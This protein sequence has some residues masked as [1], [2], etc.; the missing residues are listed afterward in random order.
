MTKLENG[1]IRSRSRIDDLFDQLQGAS[2]FSKV[3]MRSSYQQLKAR[4]LR[5]QRPIH[6]ENKHSFDLDSC[7]SNKEGKGYTKNDF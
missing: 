1:A 5:L 4:Y 2:Y 6:K 3:D 7:G